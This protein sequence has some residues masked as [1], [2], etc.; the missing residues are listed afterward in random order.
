MHGAFR[1]N[2]NL[3][4]SRA[5]GDAYEKPFIS[6]IPEITS[7]KLQDGDYIVL[8]SDGLFD[9]FTNQGVVDYLESVIASKTEEN[10]PPHLIY[11]DLAQALAREAL[12]RKSYD[13]VTVIIVWRKR[14]Y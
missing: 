3:S 9:V 1:M 13:H 10:K 5:V 6:H 11:D 4:L 7:E 2:N 14:P 12:R 8:A